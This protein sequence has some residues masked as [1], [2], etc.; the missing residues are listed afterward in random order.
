MPSKKSASSAFRFSPHVK[1]ALA[2]IA[3]RDGRSM[4]NLLEWL[5]RRRAEELGLD[6]PIP[7]GEEAS[8]RTA[9]LDAREVGPAASAEPESH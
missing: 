1:A 7:A 5:I 9:K 3:Q 4:A 8:G 2:L 6:W